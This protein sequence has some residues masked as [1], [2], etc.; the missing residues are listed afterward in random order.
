MAETG[1]E[2]KRTFSER[3]VMVRLP[4]DGFKWKMVNLR[5]GDGA[6]LP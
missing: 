6:M 3:S 1:L 5:T 4:G 2:G